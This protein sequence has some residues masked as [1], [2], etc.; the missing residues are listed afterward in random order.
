M[1]LHIEKKI[2]IYLHPLRKTIVSAIPFLLILVGSIFAPTRACSQISEVN[3]NEVTPV[4]TYKII[5]TYPHDPNAFTQGLVYEGGFL[6]E[7]TGLH[8]RS[9]LR[10]VEL[11]TGKVLKIHELPL[12]FFGEGITIYEDNII[13]LTWQSNVGFVYAKKTF[14]LF[15]KFYYPFEGWGITHDGKHLIVSDGTPTLHFLSPKTF[16]EVYQIEVFDNK[17]PIAKLNELEW[18]E[19]EIYA[20]V[21]QTDLIA[22]IDQRTGQVVGWIDLRGLMGLEDYE[23]PINVLNGIAFDSEAKRLFVTGK[24]W[25]KLFEIELVKTGPQTN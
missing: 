7:G 22:R 3:A 10:K 21:W 1:E 8:G 6:Y 11:E 13:Q 9:S 18:V 4:Y 5:N 23:K 17:G 24:L 19:G 16:E 15:E 2:L 14:D 12:Q 25:P 20:N